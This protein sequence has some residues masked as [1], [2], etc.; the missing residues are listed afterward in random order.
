MFTSPLR[1]VAF[2]TGAPAQAMFVHFER[3]LEEGAQ[4]AD[5]SRLKNRIVGELDAGG[6]AK[7]KRLHL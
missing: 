6:I 1:T 2:Y 4:A 5:P 3:L 7:R